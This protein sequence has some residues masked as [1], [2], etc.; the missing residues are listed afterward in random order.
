MAS[1]YIGEHYVSTYILQRLYYSTSAVGSSGHNV[2]VENQLRRTNWYGGQTYTYPS[3]SYISINGDR[4]DW[5]WSSGGYPAIPAYNNDW[6]TFCSRTVYVGHSSAVNV[7]VAGGNYNMG[8]YLSGDCGGNVYLEALYTAPATPSAENLTSDGTPHKAYSKVTNNGWGTNSSRRNFEIICGGSIKA[9]DYNNSPASMYWTLPNGS[10][11]TGACAIN[12]WYGRAV[13][14]H[15]LWT[16]SGARYVATPSAPIFTITAGSG[17]SPSTTVSGTVTYKGGTQ[18]S[19]TCNNGTIKRWQFGKMTSTESGVPST[20][21]SDTNSSATT[22]SYTWARSNFATGNNYKLYARV[23]NTLGGASSTTSN[24]IYCPTGVSG[25]LHARTTESLTLKGSANSAG[26]INSST[27]GTISCYEIKWSTDKATVDGGGGTSTGLQTNNTFTIENLSNDQTV[28]YRVYAWNIYG[29]SNVS[30][31]LSATTLPRYTPSIT[32]IST[33]P[34]SPGGNVSLTIGRT[35]GMTATELVVTGITLSRKPVLS[36]TYTT[37]KTITGLSLISGDTYTIENAWTDV[38]TNEGNYD[39]KL[40]LTNGIDVSDTP[41]T[42]GAPTSVTMTANLAEGE[43][44][45]IQAKGT[46]ATDTQLYKWDLISISTGQSK[47]VNTSSTTPTILTSNHLNYGTNYVLKM[48]AYNTYGLWRDSATVTQKT[49]PRFQFYSV[50]RGAVKKADALFKHRNSESNITEVYYIVKNALGNVQIGDDLYN[51]RLTFITQSL[52]Y[53]PENIASVLFSDGRKIAYAYDSTDDLY[54]FGIWRGNTLEVVFHDG[55]NWQMT[56]Y[57]F[58]DSTIV[59]ATSGNL[60]ASAAFSTTKCE[61]IPLWEQESITGYG[62]ISYY[63][64]NTYTTTSQIDIPS[65]AKVNALAADDSGDGTPTSSWST[66]IDG[67][68]I[69]NENIKSII[70]TNSVTSLPNYFLANATRLQSAVLA[71]ANTNSI[72]SYTFYGCT[73]LLTASLPSAI[74]SIP[75]YVFYNCTSLNQTMN[76]PSNVTSIGTY[77][78]AFCMRQNQSVTLPESLTTIGDY[79]MSGC[80]I[81]DQPMIIPNSVEYIGDYFM[82]ANLLFDRDLTLPSSLTHLGAG[83][84]YNCLNMTHTIN[85]GTLVA[86]VATSSN[87]TMS[88]LYNTAACYVTGI[89]IR[90]DTQTAWVTRFGGRDES[91]YRYTKG[92]EEPIVINRAWDYD[93]LSLDDYTISGYTGNYGGL[94]WSDVWSIQETDTNMLAGTAYLDMY[95]D[96]DN[97]ETAYDIINSAAFINANGKCYCTDFSTVFYDTSSWDYDGASFAQALY[98]V[99][100]PTIALQWTSHGSS[101]IETGINNYWQGRYIASEGYYDS[102]VDWS[103]GAGGAS[104]AVITIT[105]TELIG[106]E[107][108]EYYLIGTLTYYNGQTALYLSDIDANTFDSTTGTAT[109]PV[110]ASGGPLMLFRWAGAEN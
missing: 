79:F 98:I 1:G 107:D 58:E 78:M 17:T 74:T 44:I 21:Q 91:P 85:V 68:T 70:L 95:G 77:F 13:N 32:N 5:G 48:R 87:D 99:K 20:F 12:T 76:L 22:K 51:K 106:I 82:S 71:N 45:Q 101:T 96:F 104:Q 57:E 93:N 108:P 18:N 9:S 75:S 3:N 11:N 36:S 35:G 103:G 25:S 59:S 110:G 102:I 62:R 26:T 94:P 28:Y 61:D 33:S 40:T 66:T 83:F 60:N 89:T 46:A 50:S 84:L 30:N 2:Y 90:G 52:R 63:T 10:N 67:V 42:V 49:S 86:T 23:T 43:P 14:N 81:F 53:R 4:Y 19:T 16:D 39:F 27:G 97:Y 24:V 15:V 100:N 56:E 37:L 92:Y 55:W 29:L 65:Q 109:I 69:T 41:F 7:Y 31:T 105:A 73:S 47:T 80:G 54:K 64:D 8:S 6:H 88:T 38:A 72:G 34:L